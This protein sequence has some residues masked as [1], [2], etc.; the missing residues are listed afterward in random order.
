[1]LITT[2]INENILDKRISASDCPLLSKTLENFGR[3]A[4]LNAPSANIFL[5]VLAN[6]TATKKQS[7][8]ELI[9]RKAEK[10]HSLI[11][12]SILLKKVKTPTVIACLITLIFNYR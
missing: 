3:N 9:P 7:K 6:L 12:P 8:K 5:Q 11:N 10:R 2:T 1:M 4:A